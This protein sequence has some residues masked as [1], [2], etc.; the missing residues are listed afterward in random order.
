MT[1]LVRRTCTEIGEDDRRDGPASSSRPLEAFRETAAYVLLGAPGAGKTEAFRQE[2][3]ECANGHYVTARDFVTFDDRPEWH[4]ATLFIDGLDEMRAGAADGRTPFDNIRSKLDTLGQPGIRLSCREAH[5]FGANDRSHLESVSRDGKVKVLRLDLLSEDSVREILRRRPG[6]EDADAFLAAARD[7][8]IDGL[9]ANPQSM[10]MLADAVA[11]G[12]WPASRMQTFELAC[13]K[14]VR[15]SSKEHQPATLLRDDVSRLLD[16]AG[17]LCAVQLLTGSAGYTWNSGAPDHPDYPGLEQVPGDDRCVLRHV[18]DSRLFDAPFGDRSEGRAAPVHRQIAEFLAAGYLASLID[19]G[20]PIGRILSLIA[21][22]DG[23]VVSDL[24]GLSAWLAAHS[25]TARAELIACDP[26]GTM[27]YGDVREFSTHEKRH[28]LDGLSREATSRPWIAGTLAREPRLADLATPDMADLFG[29]RLSEPAREDAQ[30]SLVLLLLTAL[31]NGRAMPSL[32]NLIVEIVRDDAW[33]RGVRTAALE[34][35]TRD[36]VERHL[37]DNASLMALLKGRLAVLDENTSLESGIQEQD[38]EERRQRQRKWYDHVRAHEQELRANRCPPGF[39]HNLAAAYFGHFVDVEGDTPLNRLRSLLG[40][41]EGL[42]QTVLQGLRGSITRNDLPTDA[43]I[44]RLG[45]QSRTHCLAFPIMAGLEEAIHSGASR[46]L[47]LDEN[48]MRVALAIH[49]TVAT[50]YAALRPPSWFPPLLTSYPDA[51]ADVLVQSVLSGMRAGVD[52][53]ANLYDLV[54]SGGHEKVARLATLPLLRKFPVRCTDRQMSALSFLLEAALLYCERTPL[55][56]LVRKKLCHRSMNVAQRVY[57]LTAGVIASPNSFT[58]DLKNFVSGNERRIRHLAE[59]AVGRFRLPESLLTRLDVPAL[60][61]LICLTGSSFRPF[62]PRSSATDRDSEEGGPVTRGMEAALGIAQFI[63]RLASFPSRI[64]AKALEELST[65]ASLRP[66]RAHLVDAAYRQNVL[67]REHSFRHFGVGQVLEVL[68][69][70]RPAN[71]ADLAA[72]T[73]SYLRKIA[74]GI[75]DGKT[76]DWRQ[77]WNVDPHNRPLVPKPEDACRDALLSDLQAKLIELHIDAQPEG[78]YAD[79]KRSDIRVSHGIFNVPV[80]IKKSCHRD[81]WSAIRT[82][83]I[84]KYT[85]DPDTGG[86]GIYL[87]FWHGVGN[88]QPPESGT[89]PKN[90][91]TLEERLRGTLSTEEA[92]LIS[93]LV[94][95][96]SKPGN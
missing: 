96:V 40:N 7:R 60:R 59:F 6:I 77:Y 12:V 21:G 34:A 91:A 54:H 9:L 78:C 2:A 4:G 45:S 57:W 68:D 30:Q 17:R 67:R 14:L 61:L 50:P 42:I 58:T 64:A 36:D 38:D 85:R 73:M 71:A 53:S 81:L 94:V 5:W 18:L 62:S 11:A 70:R 89:I 92:R 29:R 83:L 93:I 10:E 47:S 65:D 37:A 27:L 51:V 28:V 32:A 90:A 1:H 8:G 3:A 43:E 46:E 66:W 23:I 69:K 88:C 49:Y 31:R 82:Q 79:D 16:A 24:R 84:A 87:V 26:L 39:L 56:A 63:D 55:L 19:D 74:G 86:Y 41:D 44:I 35:L 80:E 13:R 95:D 33:M 25:C 22:H 52:I 75:R 48:Q 76:S 72:L 15:E 20:L